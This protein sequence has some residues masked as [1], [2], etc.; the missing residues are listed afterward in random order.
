MVGLYSLDVFAY[1]LQVSY[2]L[3]LNNFNNDKKRTENVRFLYYAELAA[4]K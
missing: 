1:L 3:S 4:A 2:I